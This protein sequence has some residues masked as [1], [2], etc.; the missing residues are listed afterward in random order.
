MV[1]V[2]FSHQNLICSPL[3]IKWKNNRRAVFI[4]NIFKKDREMRKLKINKK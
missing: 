1:I 4:E 2:Q 3:F